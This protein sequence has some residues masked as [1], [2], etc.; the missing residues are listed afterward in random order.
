MAVVV[1]SNDAKVAVNVARVQQKVMKRHK[2]RMKLIFEPK[3]VF[4]RTPHYKS[5]PPKCLTYRV[6]CVKINRQFFRFYIVCT[7]GLT[8]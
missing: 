3:S 4:A 5:K 7:A 8:I 1:F 6:P 2:E